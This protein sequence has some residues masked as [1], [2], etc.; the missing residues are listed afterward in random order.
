MVEVSLAM[1]EKD[2]Q[3][4]LQLRDDLDWIVAPGC[5][6]LFGGHLEPGE[7][8][9]DA[10]RRELLEEIRWR[11]GA[12][13]HWFS[14][15]NEQRMLHYFHTTLE[16]PLDQLQLLEGQDVRLAGTRELRQGVLWSSVLGEFRPLAPS[17]QLAVERLRGA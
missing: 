12:M 2:G 11:A 9:E 8:P 14:H 5:W 10:L 7:T 16:E 1:V 17:L 13:R 3:W 15:G 4:L 6:G